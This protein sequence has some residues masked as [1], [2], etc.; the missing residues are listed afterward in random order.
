M[1]SSCY[2]FA[3]LTQAQAF[4]APPYSYSPQTIGLFNLAIFVGA[5]IGLFTN[6]FFSDWV[7]AYL[8]RRNDGVREPE[9]RLVAMV[10][11]VC[12]MILGCVVVAVGYDQ[13]WPWEVIVI[14]GYLMLGVQVATLP[15][16][17][18]AYAVDSYKPV[19]GPLFVAITV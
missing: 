13:A 9:M 12:A 8:T 2:L 15:S 6:G 1:T 18:A 7:A 11:Y 5:A 14:V 10:P 16:I 4:A 17:A 3:N 19:T